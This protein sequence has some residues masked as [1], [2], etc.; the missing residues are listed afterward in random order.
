RREDLAAEVQEE[1]A[2]LRNLGGE[3]LPALTSGHRRKGETR[4]DQNDHGGER[5]EDREAAGSTARALDHGIL[6]QAC[7][8][9]NCTP[10]RPRI[11]C[12]RRSSNNGFDRRPPSDSSPSRATFGSHAG[13]HI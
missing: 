7:T 8:V 3:A 5:T 6:R 1:E 11:V 4:G 2:W 9:R 13:L 12:T 10:G